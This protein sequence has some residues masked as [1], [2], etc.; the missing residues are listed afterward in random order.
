MKLKEFVKY[1]AKVCELIL[2][3]LNIRNCEFWKKVPDNCNLEL[4]IE[5]PVRILFP[6]FLLDEVGDLMLQD[7]L[8]CPLSIGKYLNFHQIDWSKDRYC[9]V[10]K[11]CIKF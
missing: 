5:L 1:N 4:Q 11:I 3:L 10:L 6:S 8:L 2:K 9:F 7:I